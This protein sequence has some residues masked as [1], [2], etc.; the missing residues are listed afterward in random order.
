MLVLH[1]KAI[2]MVTLRVT[3][4]SQRV[5]EKAAMLASPQRF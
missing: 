2:L 1:R 5:P 4:L 3:D